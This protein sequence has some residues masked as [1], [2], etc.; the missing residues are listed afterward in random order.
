MYAWYTSSTPYHVYAKLGHSC[1]T[2]PRDDLLVHSWMNG[3][4]VVLI[5]VYVVPHCHDVVIDERGMVPSAIQQLHLV[6]SIL[7]G[8]VLEQPR[9]NKRPGQNQVSFLYLLIAVCLV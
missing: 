2:V 7:H 1:Q 9:Q 6:A 4:C 3:A 5:L 8:I